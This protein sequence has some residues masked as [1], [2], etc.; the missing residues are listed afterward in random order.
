M[1]K[2]NAELVFT[3]PSA[4]PVDSKFFNCSKQKWSMCHLKKKCIQYL[5]DFMVVPPVCA[6]TS[7]ND[8]DTL[9][10]C[11]ENLKL[12]FST[13]VHEAVM[14]CC[15]LMVTFT[16]QPA[17]VDTIQKEPW[18]LH[19]NPHFQLMSLYVSAC[20]HVGCTLACC[21]FNKLRCN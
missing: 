12:E 20:A 17:A 6:I 14:S 13:Y 7:E 11:I 2:I 19:N 21:S 8:F 10:T 15:R 4:G 9:S 1:T 5:F 16:Q 3:S 18:T